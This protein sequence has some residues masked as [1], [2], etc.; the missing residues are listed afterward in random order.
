MTGQAIA[1]KG[2]TCNLSSRSP[3]SV[4]TRFAVGRGSGV[5]S[6]SGL[7]A[8][9]LGANGRGQVTETGFQPIGELLVA[10]CRGGAR[11]EDQNQKTHKHPIKQLAL[12]RYIAAIA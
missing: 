9:C 1:S 7:E 6:I 11:R 4:L 5:Q 12:E 3:T 8:P 10:T 2:K